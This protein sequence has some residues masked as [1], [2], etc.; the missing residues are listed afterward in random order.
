ME[1]PEPTNEG[2]GSAVI[3]WVAVNL[4]LVSLFGWLVLAESHRSTLPAHE[5]VRVGEAATR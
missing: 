1:E 2:S 5:T 4:S 3:V